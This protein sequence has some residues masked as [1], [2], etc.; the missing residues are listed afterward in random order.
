ML[1]YDEICDKL[2]DECDLDLIDML[3][4]TPDDIV[5]R[6]KDRIEQQLEV[7]DIYYTDED[8]VEM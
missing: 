3:Y 5:D 4:I 2:R 8:E 1:T 7:L 6:F